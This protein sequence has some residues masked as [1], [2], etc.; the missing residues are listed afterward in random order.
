MQLFAY[1]KAV[2]SMWLNW[3]NCLAILLMNFL[4]L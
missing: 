2:L 4:L 1:K 3:G